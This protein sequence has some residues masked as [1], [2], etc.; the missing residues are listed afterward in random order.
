MS[1]T[2]KEL[3]TYNQLQQRIDLLDEEI[4][5]LF[6]AQGKKINPIK[7]IIKAF[8]RTKRK[9]YSHEVEIRLTLED[10]RLLQDAR[11]REVNFLKELIKED[12]NG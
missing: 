8:S 6:E 4:Y 9:D 11:L 2:R 3:N 7:R 5:A 1:I 10:I 12:S